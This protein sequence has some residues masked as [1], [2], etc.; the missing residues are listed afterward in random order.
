MGVK[1]LWTLLEP[2]ARPV[3]LEALARKRL[4][5]DASIW[6]Y[7]LLKA[8]R[9]DDGSP[10]DNA[11]ILG[12]YRRIC[13]LLFYDIR[14]VFVFDG[15][16]PE[17]KRATVADRKAMRDSKTQDARRTARQLLQTHLKLHA[18]G[19]HDAANSPSPSLGSPSPNKKRKRDE[20][21]LPPMQQGALATRTEN[22]HDLRMAHPDDLRQLVKLAAR[23]PE[24]LGALGDIEIDVE[25][26]EFKA[27]PPEDQHDIIVA[28]KVHSRQTSHNRLQHML[29]SS[30]NALDFS[31][32]QI[33]LLVKRNNL[34]QQWLQ[35]TGNSHRIS[36]LSS[37]GTT[38]TGRIAGERNREYTLIKTEGAV[39]GWT[40]KMH[41]GGS[42]KPQD[43]N[44]AN[45]A[46]AI[47][48]PSSS[49]SSSSTNG[50]IQGS[51][52]DVGSDMFEEVDIP[53]AHI[54]TNTQQ[55]PV[56]LE[57]RCQG[58]PIDSLDFDGASD[59]SVD[60]ASV[61]EVS[62][63][64]PNE[65]SD[66]DES[67]V[68]LMSYQE[69]Q[70]REA[71]MQKQLERED[72]AILAMPAPEFLSSWMQL[73]TVQILSHDSSICAKMQRWL[74][75][76]PESLVAKEHW[77][78]SRRLEKQP[79]VDVDMALGADGFDIERIANISTQRAYLSLATNYLSF[80]LRWR[81]MRSAAIQSDDMA[82]PFNAPELDSEGSLIEIAKA[83]S[84]SGTGN[85][86]DAAIEDA[87][88]RMPAPV[89][90]PPT[91]NEQ[92]RS[93]E[94]T[95]VAAPDV[96]LL[97]DSEQ[98]PD[99]ESEPQ[100]HADGIRRD[101]IFEKARLLEETSSG[102]V[103]SA[104][105][106]LDIKAETRVHNID[107]GSD[108]DSDGE[109][110][111]SNI[112][113]PDS[114]EFTE[115]AGLKP[116]AVQAAML[117]GSGGTKV[118]AIDLD[119]EMRA[120]IEI[121]DSDAD[122]DAD[123]EGEGHG[124]TEL[125]HNEQNEYAR[126]IERLK[127]SSDGFASKNAGSYQAVRTELQNELNSLRAQVRDNARDAAGVEADMVKDIRMLLTLFGIPYITAPSEAEAQCAA[128]IAAGLVDGM[129]TD[130]SDAF[131]FATSTDT[132]V[133]RH[134]F[135]KDRFVE[136]YSSAAIRQD[137]SIEQRDLVFLAY[138][139]GSDYTV[140]IKGIGPVLAM[141]ALAEF[142]PGTLC[143]PEDAVNK[144]NVGDEA[145]VINALQT[146]ASW[147]AAVNE[148]LPGVEIPTELVC[149][150]SR[151]R[152]A[153]T[154]RKASLPASFPDARVAH[155]YFHPN[156]DDSEAKFAWGFPNLELLRQ[157]LGEKLGWTTDKTD[158]TLVPLAR[159]MAEDKNGGA[160]G[161]ARPK[162][163][164]LTLGS[165]APGFV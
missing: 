61:Y 60:G 39:A 147:C 54:R 70:E 138:L 4:A 71:E 43:S 47:A 38:A 52:S 155:A 128:L 2:A 59:G 57:G 28:L 149:T 106:R 30:E 49:S 101:T 164:E 121:D 13:K 44:D 27:L 129:V 46:T 160:G 104:K 19:G 55:I 153:Q 3:R 20:Y 98:E 50:D 107:S 33:D 130:D 48:I 76:D 126:F 114:A 125:L 143:A 22:K 51:E 90:S 162:L 34:T 137:S 17:L 86:A 78:V 40:L 25:S 75:E 127:G 140:G 67:D 77:S 74:L 83:E 81:Q 95:G 82:E 45:L 21:E 14:P 112:E 12:F 79:N 113:Q 157:F 5:V 136:M 100:Y 117:E 110:Y 141:E 115:H 58:M 92:K 18:L 72:Q 154:I 23:N 56:A 93:S 63:T 16:A 156:V 122:S 91:E 151:R 11:H 144:D 97:T 131:L 148:V 35:V 152:L 84:A 94:A 111:L 134:F 73:V 64:S 29:G 88:K 62:S 85:M 165:N 132:R 145:R 89:Q 139:L 120:D 87:A 118:P 36:K 69:R 116:G 158:E 26:D 105:P 124:H 96:F 109:E 53:T 150:P 159:R 80:V 9:D 31:K 163:A 7:Q 6:L 42:E 24:S 37:S 8:M 142:G 146:F 68:L 66:G 123:L 65:Y 119:V 135:Q 10:V 103:A 32:Q 108:S 41:G 99:L 161:G 15:A 1:G 102:A 133:Y